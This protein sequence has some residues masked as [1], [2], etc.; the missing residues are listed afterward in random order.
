MCVGVL[1][2]RDR[3]AAYSLAELHRVL[4]SVDEQLPCHAHDA[5]LWFADA[6]AD[7]EWA[8]ALCGGC[9]I[10]DTC[11][12]GALVRREPCGVWGGELLDRGVV[13]PRKRPRGRP[14]KDETAA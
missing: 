11:L 6:P 14:R 3:A 13:I 2:E 5:E 8:K 9:P 1:D 7:V 10:R 4:A 12:E